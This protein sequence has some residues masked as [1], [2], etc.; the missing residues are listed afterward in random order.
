[1]KYFHYEVPCLICSAG[2]REAFPILI[3]RLSSSHCSSLGC[4]GPQRSG[5]LWLSASL[6]MDC[7]Q[8]CQGI[9]LMRLARHD[10]RM[11]LSV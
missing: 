10:L 2:I 9:Q 4:V 11:S 5:M 8:Q 3:I 7:G 1:M 6:S